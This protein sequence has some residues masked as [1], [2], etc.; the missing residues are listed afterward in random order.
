[1]KKILLAIVAIAVTE[2][3]TISL[4]SSTW[5]KTHLLHMSQYLQRLLC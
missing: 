5:Q 3:L 2:Q 4:A 1:M